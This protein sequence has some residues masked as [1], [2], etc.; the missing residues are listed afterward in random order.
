MENEE[1]IIRELKMIQNFLM[2][3][4]EELKKIN[5]VKK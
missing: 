1:K 2:K 5:E 3:I 4:I